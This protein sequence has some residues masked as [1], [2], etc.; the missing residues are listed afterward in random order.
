MASCDMLLVQAPVCVESA[1][2]RRLAGF[3][4]GGLVCPVE[5]CVLFRAAFVPSILLQPVHAYR[6]YVLYL[7]V[8]SMC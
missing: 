3:L 7:C 2:V 1:Q 4:S 8:V 5:A 6:I